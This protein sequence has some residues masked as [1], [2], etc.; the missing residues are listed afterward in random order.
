MTWAAIKDAIDVEELERALDIVVVSQ[1]GD[2]DMARCPLSTHAGIDRNPS[3]SINRKKKLFNCF[4]CGRGGTLISLVED[5]KKCSYDEAYSFC[6]LYCVSIQSNS[7]KDLL[8]KLQSIMHEHREEDAEVL[9]IFRESILNGWTQDVDNT[10]FFI[11]RGI[12]PEVITLLKLGYDAEHGRGN[13]IGPAAIIP[14]FWENRLVGYQERWLGNYPEGIPKYTNSKDFP[15]KNTIYNYHNVSSGDIIVVES[16][17]TVAYLMSL[18]HNAI[19][20]FGASVQPE[21]IRLIKN[22]C[23]VGSRVFLSYDN[24]VAGQMATSRIVKQLKNTV[25][26]FI[27]E[28]PNESKGDLNDL[29]PAEVSARI[30]SATPWWSAKQDH[31]HGI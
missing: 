13:Y 22:L 8:F 15:K 29:T 17:M 11:K 2:E 9:P 18:G 10:D 31:T 25:P 6:R 27:I 20:T 7:N 30:E 19:A 21:Q 4:A 16:A 26:L 24:D 5:I 23:S 12:S 14:H 28:P 1:N 3:F